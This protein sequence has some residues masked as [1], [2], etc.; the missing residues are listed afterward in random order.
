MIEKAREGDITILKLPPHVT[1]KIQP[2]DVLCFTPL[3]R[4]WP[5]LLNERINVL[6]PKE[7]ISK[8]VFVDLLFQVWC[9]GHSETNIISRFRAT[10]IFPTN[11]NK[12]NI[13][14]FDQ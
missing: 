11:R 5:E 7:S 12:Y 4:A 13:K 9:K 8:S 6:G 14:H 10:G 2:L 1:D 3:K